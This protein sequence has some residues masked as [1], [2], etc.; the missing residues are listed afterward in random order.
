MMK[1][2]QFNQA[3]EYLEA[4]VELWPEECAYQSALGWTLFKKT[5]PE[6]ARAREHLEKALALDDGDA[7][8]H[9]RISVVLKALGEVEKAAEHVRRAK[10]ID[11]QA[12]V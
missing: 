4:S 1:A 10:E 11:P 8:T 7:S 12:R 3:I 2:G 9:I 6:D 5:P